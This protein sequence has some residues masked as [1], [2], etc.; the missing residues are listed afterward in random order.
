MKNT[1]PID[2]TIVEDSSLFADTE[3]G[4]EINETEDTV[5]I[6]SSYIDGLNMSVESDNMKSLM[7]N[8]YSE[9]L[10]TETDIQ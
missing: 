8:I 5:T 1:N 4:A 7:K 2:V 3:M 9:A 6:L 10:A